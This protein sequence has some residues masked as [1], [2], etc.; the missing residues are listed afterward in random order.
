MK[1]E[2]PESSRWIAVVVLVLIIINHAKKVLR[3]PT[4]RIQ[5]KIYVAM[6]HHEASASGKP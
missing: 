2:R 6:A 1:L 5:N 3:R 4:G